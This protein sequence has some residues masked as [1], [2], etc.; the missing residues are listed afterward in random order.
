MRASGHAFACSGIT[1]F[2][3]GSKRLRTRLR[4]SFL[5]LPYVIQVS[6]HHLFLL[7]PCSLLVHTA[8]CLEGGGTGVWGVG[9]QG[10]RRWSRVFLAPFY[11]DCFCD[12]WPR[13]APAMPVSS[14]SSRFLFPCLSPTQNAFTQ[15]AIIST[16]SSIRGRDS[17]SQAVLTVL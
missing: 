15:N 1:R 17:A 8:P 7:L 2:S 11:G 13:R 4:F 14:S 3:Y 5:L 10:W 6:P 16:L 9:G 12:V